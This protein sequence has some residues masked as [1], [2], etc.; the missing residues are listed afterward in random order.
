M[1]DIITVTANWATGNLTNS[2]ISRQYDNNRYRV[3]FTGYPEDG[4]ENLIF[5]LLVFMRT[6]ENPR[7]VILPP[8]QLSSD[9]WLISNYFTQLSQQIRFQ[10]CVQ[11]EA[12]TFEAHSPIFKGTIV[13]SLDHVGEE[14]D[15]DTSALFD[16]YREYINQLIIAAG[17][18]V[19]DTAL[20]ETSENP[21]QNKAVAAAFN[22]VNGR[23][24]LQEGEI[25]TSRLSF[26]DECNYPLKVV[27]TYTRKSISG[28]VG[29]QIKFS[30]SSVMV[31][32][33]F[34][35]PSGTT[36]VYPIINSANTRIT[37]VSGVILAKG[38][39]SVN[40]IPE[41]GTYL[42]ILGNPSVNDKI[43]K[44]D[45][46]WFTGPSTYEYAEE[47]TFY[48]AKHKA[49]YKDLI[50]PVSYEELKSI[51]NYILT[52]MNLS[53]ADKNLSFGNTTRSIAA[54]YSNESNV[55]CAVNLTVNA[56]SANGRLMYHDSVANSW[57]TAGSVEQIAESGNYRFTCD[58]A[59][60]I[61]YNNADN[62][63][64]TF[65]GASG[66]IVINDLKIYA[67][68]NLSSYD[69]YDPSF[70]PMM[71]NVFTKLDDD[72][73]YLTSPNGTK[74]RLIVSNSGVLSVIPAKT[75]VIPNN[76]LIM[77]NSLVFGFGNASKTIQFGMA[78]TRA[79]YDYANR[80]IA[81]TQAKNPN[82]VSNKLYSSP[83][84]HSATLEAAQTFLNDNTAYWNENVDMVIVQM[85]DNVNTA[86]KR[87]VFAES[88]PML[89]EKIKE[90][91]P[92]AVII[93]VGIW[94]NNSTVF[95]IM[96]STAEQNG[97]IFVD[98][99]SIRNSDTEGEL[100][101]TV[102]FDDG[103]TTTVT[104]ARK[105]HPGNLGMERIAEA[106]ENAVSF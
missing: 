61:Q 5:Y 12:G 39:D 68:G 38:A 18:V 49:Y 59:S 79:E 11:N 99:R 83:F 57:K 15:I 13:D 20:D 88:F 24:A 58:C 47:S 90:Q 51:P 64:L 1:A 85:G 2:I 94:F 102:Y 40:N 65:Y 105:T 42:Y 100:G 50:A 35:I 27:E 97:C 34:L 17:A 92:N 23:L 69:Y 67:E 43:L 33:K 78:A 19:I 95:N 48:S 86:E 29:E 53:D 80:F 6:E 71:Q 104:E 63:H 32:K 60:L 75:S 82:L 14:I 103:T 10:L 106:I 30:D 25:P 37:D 84:E 98:I 96:K 36:S 77:G 56:T 22:Q 7:G 91:S 44:D 9:Q 76:L 73:V 45:I 89:I 81:Y 41:G 66:T 74:Y 55:V 21:V 4:T 16:A 54:F 52:E 93:V 101:A 46:V 26:V 31:A 70:I 72:N 8:V 3:E 87:T 28:N 62:F